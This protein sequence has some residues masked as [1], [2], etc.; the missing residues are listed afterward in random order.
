MPIN[1]DSL[2]NQLNM[3][4]VQVPAISTVYYN[5]SLYVQMNV[6]S[7]VVVYPDKVDKYRGFLFEISQIEIPYFSEIVFYPF[8]KLLGVHLQRQRIPVVK[9]AS[10]FPVLYHPHFENQR[11]PTSTW[12][13]PNRNINCDNL[14]AYILRIAN[15]LQYRDAYIDRQG[16]IANYMA[17]KWYLKSIDRNGLFPSDDLQL[18][19]LKS[20]K[21]QTLMA[22]KQPKKFEVAKTMETEKDNQQPSSSPVLESKPRKKFEVTLVTPAYAPVEKIKPSFHTIEELSSNFG[23]D[24]Y[25]NHD[26]SLK[27]EEGEWQ[28]S[29]T[30]YLT[31][32]AFE[33]ISNHIGWNNSTSANCVEQG[34]ILLGH[35]YVDPETKQI[36][37][38]AE[39]SVAGKS[40]KGSGAYLEM[41]HET[42]KEM[43]D[44]VDS[45]HSE[46][47][48]VGWYHTHPNGLPVFMSGTDM[49]TQAR[50]F[51]NDWQ[52]AIV[53]NPHK[54]IWRAFYGISS[55]EC[56]GYVLDFSDRTSH[57][58]NKTTK[59]EESNSTI[60]SK[61]AISG[62]L[63]GEEIKDLNSG[64]SHK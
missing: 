16:K 10:K 55:K 27:N 32:Q 60:L 33:S 63:S 29:H 30:F 43:L 1:S 44:V 36:F 51:G 41:T 7:W 56:H 59:I 52:F 9:L 5:N 26:D 61:S 13:E 58:Q 47:Q 38:I 42:W 50:I 17:L 19:S 11:Y 22:T 46:L 37:C 3:P 8:E 62:N 49:A 4:S 54:K 2:L 40:A 12:V 48:I 31:R 21:I 45:L 28:S 15:S 57:N 20:F 6:Q 35:T 39:Q 53:L 34:G 23:S 24:S 18:P 14:G 64:N 25:R